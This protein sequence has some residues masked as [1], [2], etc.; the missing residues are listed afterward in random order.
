MGDWKG[1]RFGL[2]AQLE[3]YNLKNDRGETTNV[4]KKNP[5]VVKKIETYLATART[6]SKH[7]PVRERKRTKKTK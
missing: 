5:S 4:A 6:D 2:Q 7:F 1:V 3:L